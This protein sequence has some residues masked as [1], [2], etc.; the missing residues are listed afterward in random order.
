MYIYIY[1]YI[2]I[3]IHT[4]VWYHGRHACMMCRRVNVCTCVL[5]TIHTCVCIHNAICTCVACI[6]H[7]C[8]CI[9]NRH[10]RME[11][12][13]CAYTIRTCVWDAYQMLLHIDCISKYTYAYT[14]RIQ[15]RSENIERTY[16][17]RMYVHVH[18]MHVDIY[19][20]HVNIYLIHV[21][22]T[23]RC[24]HAYSI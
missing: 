1:L 17:D 16:V 2:Y 12:S 3:Y 24:T 10:L 7:T 21:V 14:M 23:L 19:T 18:S 15:C 9:H 6:I 11:C 5:C 22:C 13:V 20:M 8:V 4:C